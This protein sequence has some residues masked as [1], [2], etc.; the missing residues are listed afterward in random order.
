MIIPNDAI[1][2]EEKVRDYL[3]RPLEEGDK[4]LFLNRAGYT[5]EEWWELLR[6][7]R[8]QILPAE[9]RFSAAPDLVSD[10]K[11]AEP[12]AVRMGESYRFELFGKII[13][14]RNGSLSR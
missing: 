14:F 8:E 6:D 9:A 1:I 12:C 4:S 2:A 7:L 5:Q 3:L 10:M 13:V 11:C